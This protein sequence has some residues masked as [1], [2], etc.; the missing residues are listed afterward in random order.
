MKNICFVCDSLHTLVSGS[1]YSTLRF[2]NI[3]KKEYNI[4]CIETHP[5]YKN[6]YQI[7]NGIKIYY[8]N[9]ILCPFT[10][11]ELYFGVVTKNKL[12]DILLNENIDLIYTIL[13]TLLTINTL[14]VAKKLKI[15]T[16]SSS[17]AQIQNIIGKSMIS[18]S[19]AQIQ[20]IT[21]KINNSHIL[22]KLFCKYLHYIYS[23]ADTI[24]FPS[25]FAKNEL[26]T[27]IPSNRK[28]NTKI[29][30]NGVDHNIYK[31]SNDKGRLKEKYEIGG[32]MVLLYVGRISSEKSIQTLINSVPIIDEQF[33]N[34]ILFIIGDGPMINYLK[35]LTKNNKMENK[36]KFMGRVSESVKIN[37]YNISDIFIFPTISELEGMVV[38]E[39]M[40]CKNAI[41]TSDSKNNASKMF[42]NNNGLIFENKNH[43]DLAN[44]TLHLLENPTLLEKMKNQS[45]KISKNYDISISIAKLKDIIEN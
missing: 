15:K 35:T 14:S 45:Y 24:V 26:F 21:G 9:S 16:V 25:E 2:I 12:K 3:L 44:K 28:N 4:I 1:T 22:N 29:I 37:F 38:L 17:H 10:N 39:A 40:A 36:I 6:G 42:I 27:L 18:S 7:V 13:P 20:N 41:I 33:K 19:H 31:Y 23:K 8:V 34:F 32:K 5:I 43:I 11:S 30:S